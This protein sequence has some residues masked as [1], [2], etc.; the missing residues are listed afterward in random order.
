MD[1]NTKLRNAI[2]GK[3]FKKKNKDWSYQNHQAQF[4]DTGCLDDYERGEF[5]NQKG[6]KKNSDFLDDAMQD[7]EY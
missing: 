7:T 5:N 2:F 3:I 4:R 1:G 6:T